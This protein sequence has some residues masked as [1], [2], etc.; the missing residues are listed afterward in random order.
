MSEENEP[1]KVWKFEDAPEELKNMSTSGG[2]EDWIALIPPSYKNEYI[3]FLDEG[4]SFGCCS[5]DEFFIHIGFY[6]GYTVLIGS[7]A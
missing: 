5:V 6:E 1:I 2:D 7:H 3:G 4:T